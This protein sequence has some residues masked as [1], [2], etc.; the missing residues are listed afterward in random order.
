MT[1][2]PVISVY[3][4]TQLS[5]LLVHL[6]RTGQHRTYSRPLRMSEHH[7]RHRHVIEDYCTRYSYDWPKL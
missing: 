3:S 1:N 4:V 2:D 7:I 5:P 6:R